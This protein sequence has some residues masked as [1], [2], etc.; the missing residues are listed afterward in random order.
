VIELGFL[1]QA[2]LKFLMDLVFR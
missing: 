2:F 1:F